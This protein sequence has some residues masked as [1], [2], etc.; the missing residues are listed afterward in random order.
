VRTFRDSVISSD[1]S[2]RWLVERPR[3]E[4][5]DGVR[6]DRWVVAD[7]EGS[8]TSLGRSCPFCRGG[9]LGAGAASTNE[10]SCLLRLFA[11]LPPRSMLPR[12]EK[13][14][15]LSEVRS[16]RLPVGMMV[17]KPMKE[18]LFSEALSRP[19]ERGD[20][21]LL[22]PGDRSS[23]TTIAGRLGVLRRL[24]G[25]EG[26]LLVVQLEEVRAESLRSS[27]SHSCVRRSAED[28]GPGEVRGRRTLLSHER[29]A[30]LLDEVLVVFEGAGER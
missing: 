20:P 18:L 9:V 4:K 2:T 8:C 12:F 7:G 6:G 3:A 1:E 14:T 24:R 30:G 29:D 19:S 5:R 13:D 26:S 10:S 25:E 21:C 11:F 15:W 22:D 27:S 16:S 23:W 17:S 28:F